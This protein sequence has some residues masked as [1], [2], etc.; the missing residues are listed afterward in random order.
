MKQL[1]PLIFL[2]L[3]QVLPGQTDSYVNF[4]RQKQQTTAVVWDMPVAPTGAAPSA[5]TLEAGGALFQLWTVNQTKATD[6]LLDQKLVGA[7]LPKADVRVKTLDPGGRLPRTRVD[8]PFSV[9]I[10][11][12]GLLTGTGMPQSA[13]SVL[14]ER[15]IASFTPGVTSLDPAVVLANTPL[16]RAYLTANGRTTLQFA[17]SALTAADPTKAAGEEHFVIHALTDGSAF[18]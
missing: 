17:S 7:Y 12:S 15:H 6:Y 16:S 13:S 3:V 5:L 9:E 11:I 8:Q 14:L 18:A 2:A 10:D 4:V 1:V